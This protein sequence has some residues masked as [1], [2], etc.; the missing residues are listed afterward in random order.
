[1]WRLPADRGLGGMRRYIR[2]M[3]DIA[4]FEE[5]KDRLK[6]LRR[7]LEDFLDRHLDL[8]LKNSATFIN[9]CAKG[10]PFRRT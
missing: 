2:Y 5:C 10:I 7:D 8:R 6:E 3:D 9:R 1:M 4:I